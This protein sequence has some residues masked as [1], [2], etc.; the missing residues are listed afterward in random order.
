M[1]D[2]NNKKTNWLFTPAHL[3][4]LCNYTKWTVIFNGDATTFSKP[5]PTM[6]KWYKKHTQRHAHREILVCLTGSGYYGLGKNLYPSK[7]GTIFFFDSMEPH[8]L[9][10]PRFL[11]YQEHLWLGLLPNQFTARLI[12]IKNGK[13]ETDSVASVLFDACEF[14]CN[15]NKLLDE[16]SNKSFSPAEKK[17]LFVSVLSRMIHALITK[18]Y[19]PPPPAKNRLTEPQNIIASLMEHIKNTYGK[20]DSISS[21]ARIAGYS[22]FYF[23]RL[24]KKISGYTVH[25]YIDLCRTRKMNELQKQNWTQKAIAAELG[26]STPQSFA[27]WKKNVEQQ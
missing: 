23:S 18:G 15:A 16:I 19:M 14:N 22:E 10:Y 12:K 1:N 25:E 3:K 7:P 26:F 13:I 5:S 11:P 24:F 27:R 6:Q 2:T 17:L 21:L 8:Q 9:Q 4:I 20:G